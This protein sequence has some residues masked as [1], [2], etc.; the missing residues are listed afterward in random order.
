MK[1]MFALILAISMVLSLC[2]CSGNPDNSSSEEVIV[3]QVIVDQTGSK[4][5]TTNES[6][7]DTTTSEN[8]SSTQT[9]DT[10]ST[11]TTSNIESP[12]KK[13]QNMYV[14]VDLCDDIFQLIYQAYPIHRAYT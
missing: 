5:D 11:P 12:L 10:S 14:E 3:Q 13:Y 6:S 4:E 9:P 2:S 1:K 8:N 7:E